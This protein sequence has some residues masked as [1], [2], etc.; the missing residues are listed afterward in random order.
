[1]PWTSRWVG[2][3]LWVLH[4]PAAGATAAVS[5]RTV[6]IPVSRFTPAGLRTTRF[7]ASI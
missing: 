3:G 1:M 6:S 2:S 7:A 4:W 5:R